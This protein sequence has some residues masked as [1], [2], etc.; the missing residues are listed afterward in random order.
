[1]L[2]MIIAIV[3]IVLVIAGGSYALYERYVV[4]SAHLSQLIY[5]PIVYGPGIAGVILLILGIVIYYRMKTP[6][7]TTG[8]TTTSET[9][10]SGQP[11]GSKNQPGTSAKKSG[12]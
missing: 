8:I 12:Q 10:E 9:A 7:T 6:S 2:G 5:N 3:G 4:M 11:T 1:M